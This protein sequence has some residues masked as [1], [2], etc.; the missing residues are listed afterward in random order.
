MEYLRNSP[1]T[2]VVILL[3]FEGLI[4]V[5]LYFLAR[6]LFKQI[7]KLLDKMGEYFNNLAVVKKLRVWIDKITEAI[8][9][10]IAGLFSA[11][12]IGIYLLLILAV[13]VFCGFLAW[14]VIRLVVFG[15][16]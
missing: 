7:G 10:L 2:Q 4:I 3:L 5:G 14:R 11:V 13:I 6:L 16:W 9:Q 8:G 15:H 12:G 1:I